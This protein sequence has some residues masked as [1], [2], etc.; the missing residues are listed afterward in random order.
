MNNLTT[1]YGKSVVWA[2]IA[3][4]AG[5]CAAPSSAQ[6]QPPLMRVG[7]AVPRD[8]RDIYDRGMQYL[9]GEQSENGDWPG[10]QNGPGVTGMC[11][12]VFLASG[13]DPN[14]GIYS[15]HIRLRCAA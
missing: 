5:L 3:L 7:E 9:A 10:G 4:L 2:A 14:F 6:A 1:N 12:M 11:M 8:V 13:E 15:S